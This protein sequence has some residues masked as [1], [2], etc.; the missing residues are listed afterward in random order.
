M[1]VEAMVYRTFGPDA[2]VYGAAMLAFVTSINYPNFHTIMEKH[3]VVHVDPERWYPQQLWLDIFSD[4]ASQ[5]GGSADLVSIGMKLVDTAP[6]PPEMKALPFKDI[7]LGF[8]RGSYRMNNRGK[9]IGGIETVVISDTHLVMIDKTPYPD[10]FA[11]GAYYAMARRF[12]PRGT[13]FSVKYDES[14][15]RREHGGQAT[16]V[17]ISWTVLEESE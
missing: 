2:E 8:D 16:H 4:I 7:M 1:E 3:G 5:H 15:P 13:A 14:I 12:L 6:M 17:H 10:D 11:Y 9:D